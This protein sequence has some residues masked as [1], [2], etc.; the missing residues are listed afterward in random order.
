MATNSTPTLIGD[1]FDNPLT[2]SALMDVI[3]GL[4][5]NDTLSG[6]GGDDELDGGSGNDLMLAG[7]GNDIIHGGAGDDRINGAGGIDTVCY[8]GS[9]N[10]Y[11][12]STTASGRTIVTSI[13]AV[14]DAGRDFLRNVEQLYFAEDDYTLFL[15]GRNNKV[16]SRDDTLP[17]PTFWRMIRSLTG[18]GCASSISTKPQR[19][20]ARSRATATALPMIRA[21]RSNT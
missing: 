16:L 9:V 17:Q 12:I 6:F 11:T 8:E 2:G 19:V 21:L 15:D 3:A 4:A 1:E 13:S 20:A 5:G 18:T 14:P 10:D 7:A